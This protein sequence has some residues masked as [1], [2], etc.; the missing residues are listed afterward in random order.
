M[1]SVSVCY[2]PARFRR[3]ASLALLASAAL[4]LQLPGRTAPQADFCPLPPAGRYVVM[5]RG[6]LG[7]D[8]DQQPLARLRQESWTAAATRPRPCSMPPAGPATA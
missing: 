7:N 8:A 2:R 3:S 4:P 6:S 5:E 1:P